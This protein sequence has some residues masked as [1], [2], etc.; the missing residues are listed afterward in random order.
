MMK[1]ADRLG[2]LCRVSSG[3]KIRE[4][5]NENDDYRVFITRTV[6]WMEDEIWMYLARDASKIHVFLRPNGEKITIKLSSE[7]FWGLDW[8]EI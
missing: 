5:I 4:L 3:D 6:L 1:T 8:I 7:E 2:D